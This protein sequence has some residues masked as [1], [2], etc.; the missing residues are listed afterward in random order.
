MGRSIASPE[1][2]IT[3]YAVELTAT[4]LKGFESKGSKCPLQIIN[5][6]KNA[7]ETTPHFRNVVHPVEVMLLF[8]ILNIAQR[9]NFKLKKM[10]FLDL[11]EE[12]P[13]TL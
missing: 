6:R 8:D 1:K 9:I 10:R 5:G 7:K 13:I 11:N 4:I 3:R 2:R 12:T